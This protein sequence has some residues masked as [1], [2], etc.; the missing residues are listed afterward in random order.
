MSHNN[1]YRIKSKLGAGALM[2]FIITLSCSVLGLYIEIKRAL[3]PW[4]TLD[5]PTVFGFS[6]FIILI[7]IYLFVNIR[8]GQDSLEV[9]NI[10]RK[11]NLPFVSIS[12]VTLIPTTYFLWILRLTVRE[13]N[14]TIALPTFLMHNE[15]ELIKAIVEAASV[16]NPNVVIDKRIT[17]K[18]GVP[19]YGIFYQKAKVD[20]DG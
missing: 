2:L 19:P 3:L 15:T 17:D 5:L 13:N 8:I 7:V 6:L 1:R 4:R 11:R 12:H 20:S 14:Q 16:A 9:S 10:L 18:Y